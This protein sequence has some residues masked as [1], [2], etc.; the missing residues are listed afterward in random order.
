MD[1][2]SG[3]RDIHRAAGPSGA[4][5]PPVARVDLERRDGRLAGIGNIAGTIVGGSATALVSMP[6]IVGRVPK[7]RAFA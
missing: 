2:G 4:R 3:P 1:R 5:R 6:G 7:V